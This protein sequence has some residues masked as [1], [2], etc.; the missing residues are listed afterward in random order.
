MHHR[1]RLTVRA[2]TIDE[3]R[4]RLES[5]P[6]RS[7]LERGVR[8]KLAVL[9][10]AGPATCGTGIELYDTQAVFRDA[11]RAC[12]QASRS[13]LPGS[14]LEWMLE[15]RTAEPGEICYMQAGVFALQVAVWKMW[16]SWGIA[17]CMVSGDAAS[18]HA[19][20]CAAGV[21]SIEDG[22]RLSALRGSEEFA[23]IDRLASRNAPAIDFGC[24][25]IQQLHREGYTTFLELGPDRAAWP[26]ALE[27]L[28]ELYRAGIEID[29]PA[30]ER[31]FGRRRVTLPTYPFQRERYWGPQSGKSAHS[32]APPL[33]GSQVAGD[34][35][36]RIFENRFRAAG[37]PLLRD[38]R[39][40]GDHAFPAAGYFE[41]ALEGATASFGPA[42]YA[43]EDIA[44]AEPLIL[45]EKGDVT[46]RIR[47]IPK[48][49]DSAQFVIES[50]GVVH[51]SGRIRRDT[52]SASA[53]SLNELAARCPDAVSASEFY[54]EL[55][56]RNI[57]LGP[58]YRRM[59]EL[60]AGRGEAFCRIDA[61]LANMA[62][63]INPGVLDCCLQLLGVAHCNRS[64]ESAY[65]PVAVGR[66]FYAGVNSEP[67]YAHGIL[68]STTS[69]G[70]VGDFQLLNREGS[71]LAK[72]E[73]VHFVRAASRLRA[74]RPALE[75]CFYDVVWQPVEK[76]ADRQDLAFLPP[77]ATVAA[78]IQPDAA[79]LG[80]EHGLD[81]YAELALR[82]EMLS[83]DFVHA[84]LRRLGCV[85]HGRAAESVEALAGR[86]GVA[87]LQR[88][89]FARMLEIVREDAGREPRDPEQV[90]RSLFAGY[91][92]CETEL[93][94]I[95]RCGRKLAEVVTGQQD[96]VEL[97][98]PKGSLASLEKLYESSPGARVGNSL[99]AEAVDFALR[100]LPAS[101]T[102]RILEVGGGT[103]ATT[104]YL[105]PRLDAARTKYV[106][107]DIS[108]LFLTAAERKFQ[109][110]DFVRYA[111]LDIERAPECQGFEPHGF[112]VVLAANVL[113]AT[114]NLTETV[115]HVR[116]LLAPGGLLVLLEGI[117]KD[118]W[119]D[120]VFGLTEG[121]WRFNDA[122]RPD[123]PLIS[124]PQWL[125][126]L[127]TCG[128]SEAAAIS[129]GGSA[130]QAV[131]M[132]RAGV[133]PCGDW[134][135]VGQAD[136][137]AAS[138]A[139]LL[140][141]RG[142]S[143]RVAHEFPSEYAGSWCGVIHTASLTGESREGCY[144]A[145]QL[146]Q[147]LA[148]RGERTA[149]WLVT[150]G[151]QS[152]DSGPVPGV[153]QA[154]LWG[155]AKVV[156]IE[157]PELHCA[158]VDLDPAADPAECAADLFREIFDGSG[159]R[160]IAFRS[161]RRFVSRL[162]RS[163][164]LREP[165]RLSVP[166]A[167]F[168]LA[169]SERGVLDNLFFRLASPPPPA[170]GEIQVDVHSAGLNFLDVMDASGSLPFERGAFGAE[171]AG[172]V[173][174]VG[175]G[176][177]QWKPGDA[178]VALAPG[179]FSRLVNAP[180]IFA[181][182]KP[183]AL[184]FDE[185]A[186]IPV[187]FLTAF[188][189][190]ESLA[191][192]SAGDQVLIHAAAGGVGL[193]AVQIAQM[194]GAEIFAT[195]GSLEKRAY[196][197]SIGVHHVLDSR[198][199]G[200]AGEIE[201]LTG[202]RGVDV[203]LNSLAG[204]FIP[205]SIGVLKPRGRF[206]EIGKTG[207]W[208][209]HRFAE[210]RPQGSYL[211]Y[212][213]AR[214][215]I[216]R[217]DA[218]AAALQEILRRYHDGVLRP[219]PLKR[220]PL[221]EVID[222]FRYMAQGR[223]IGKIVLTRGPAID[224]RPNASYLITGGLGGLG[225][226]VARWLVEH[227]ARNLILVGR[228]VPKPAASEAVRR[229]ESMG[230]RVLIVNA[231]VTDYEQMAQAI[232]GATVAMPP[233]RGA[234]HAA[235]ALNDGVLLHQDAARFASVL[236][237]KVAGSWN[238]HR[239]TRDMPLDFF[240][241]FASAASV[242][243]APGQ[244]NH[245]A[246]N[247]FLDALAYHRRA[248][249]LPAISIDWGPWLDVGAAAQ[250]NVA[251]TNSAKAV[252][253]ISPDEG[254]R[255]LERILRHAPPRSVVARVNWPEFANQF[256]MAGQPFYAELAQE[257]QPAQSDV[258]PAAPGA[259][260][261]CLRRALPGERPAVAHEFVHALAVRILGVSASRKLNPRQPLNELGLDSIMALELRNLLATAAGRDLPSTLLFD[262]PTL[263]TVTGFLI[264]EM[265]ADLPAS[266]PPVAIAAV[267][268]DPLRA[269]IESLSEDQA[270]ASLMKELDH[271]G[272]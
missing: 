109:D 245:A 96:P 94:L 148:R 205:A 8:P 10:T 19:V 42:A 238:L 34:F 47:L 240:V 187:T 30:V 54:D 232:S 24:R 206:V 140:E 80:R 11:L 150:R 176:V 197:R 178:V 244:A 198:S 132:A 15:S 160:E 70:F 211:V 52:G 32:E 122:L 212:D 260:L 269:E 218:V 56:R 25:T 189:A 199:L 87:R 257:R 168:E 75:N 252:A 158:T 106:F 175:K 6:P 89:L 14:L 174:A 71:L 207:I 44:I 128:F 185:A 186:A 73:G 229:L 26:Q 37:I 81:R 166:D 21:L 219:L 194:V 36:E 136:A 153:N 264:R 31:G 98:F 242:W 53:I 65:I 95:G 127:G 79:R 23:A 46:A 102:V 82:L 91:P 156:A 203:V 101:R 192:I 113:H 152:P 130:S 55:A 149:L 59:T 107:T 265:A 74:A 27:S 188:F 167:P 208:D 99:V 258:A 169:I 50:D 233:L 266:T 243:G 250:R 117:R 105:L 115:R 93:E 61:P 143:C 213:L 221:K 134:L 248:Q 103:G 100:G 146:V 267:A 16:Q 255:A 119:I 72:G 135:I 271:A 155:L 200:F 49:V 17:P 201:R 84:A 170:L 138:L 226:L 171:C 220:Y 202:G 256:G 66:L 222:A 133:A 108:P 45:P 124:E 216:D 224:L 247:A 13:L 35:H 114:R 78:E 161:R 268:P 62:W 193:A 41:M 142:E 1:N 7:V 83:S 154:T 231:D 88:R 64:G 3:A 121:W 157:H 57:D 180:A 237:P 145:L 228:S 183:E 22:L 249:G 77:P 33:L 85:P 263:E 235:G 4:T 38:H 163:S 86:L 125:E 68:R 251:Q 165:K 139:R 164:Y 63:Q 209:D 111:L 210:M 270:E 181:A 92:D 191:R 18:E 5:G 137:F 236:G 177:T 204:E 173:V 184:S 225:L 40:H 76:T 12:E 110:S 254:L 241:L 29:W 112:D 196:L 147:A 116:Q 261:E 9:L 172:T 144:G 151:A 214:H 223:H 162:V 39:V 215:A 179:S 129:T 2:S 227:G 43:L 69:E 195:A 141:D 60:T 67:A 28:A 20:A 48:E 253:G 234:I 159:E 90:W 262:Y 123:H 118:R 126:L 58:S 272:Y 51:A 104:S 246:A 120:L 230:V 259:L 131:V 182:A 217:P 239:L 97:L 190:L